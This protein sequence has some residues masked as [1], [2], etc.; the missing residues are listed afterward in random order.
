MGLWLSCCVS[1]CPCQVCED[2]RPCHVLCVFCA[3]KD[4]SLIVRIDLFPTVESHENAIHRQFLALHTFI[5]LSALRRA[6]SGI[7]D[8]GY[9]HL[10]QH[11][12]TVDE[13]VSVYCGHL[14]TWGG[15]PDND[16]LK[17]RQDEFLLSYTK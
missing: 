6:L 15:P 1:S 9:I 17:H 13:T 3:I 5:Y 12:I 4:L 7:K 10:L 2:A 11:L 8:T 16:S 14:L